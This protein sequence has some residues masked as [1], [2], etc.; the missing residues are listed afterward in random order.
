MF[1]SRKEQSIKMMLLAAGA[2]IAAVTA[3]PAL[4]NGV[5]PA[6]AAA[7]AEHWAIILI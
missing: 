7:A 4:A 6:A 3:L 2:G 1:N 5:A